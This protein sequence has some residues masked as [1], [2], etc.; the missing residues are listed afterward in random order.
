VDADG[1]LAVL[2]DEMLNPAWERHGRRRRGGGLWF[3]GRL[4][5]G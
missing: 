5:D 1:H 2:L 3:W 4:C